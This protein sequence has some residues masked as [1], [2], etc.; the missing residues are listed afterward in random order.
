MTKTEIKKLFLIINNC[1]SNFPIDD[2]KIAIWHNMLHDI[3]FDLAQRNLREHI[4]NSP[5][6]PTPSDIIRTDLR[7]LPDH[8]QQRLQTT[9]LLQLKDVWHSEATP[10]PKH[11]LE[12]WGRK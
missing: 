5:F 12:R 4:K 3:P 7:S 8:E 1:Y 11:I 6:P 2:A 10:P 9:E